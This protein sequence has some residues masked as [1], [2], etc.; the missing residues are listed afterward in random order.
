MSLVVVILLCVALI[1]VGA[2]T[3]K[4]VGWIVLALAVIALL[5]AVLGGINIS[6]GR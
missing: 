3:G 6:V 1:L 4:P 5:L 2:T